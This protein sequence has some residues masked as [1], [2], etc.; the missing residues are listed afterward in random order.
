MVQP[1]ISRSFPPLTLIRLC[2]TLLT[3]VPA[4]LLG[5]QETPTLPQAA[6]GVLDLREYDFREGPQKEGLPLSGEWIIFDDTLNPKDTEIPRCVTVPGQWHPEKRYGAATYRITLLMPRDYP[7]LGLSLPNITNAY[8]LSLNGRPLAEGG[9]PGLSRPEERGYWKPRLLPL[10][11]GESKITLTLAFSNWEDIKGGLKRAPRLSPFPQAARSRNRRA[12]MDMFLFGAF[13][14]MGC[15][16]FFIYY[17]RKKDRSTLY[18]GLILVALSLRIIFTGNHTILL[19]FPGLPWFLVYKTSYLTLS[20]PIIFFGLFIDSL[21][22]GCSPRWFTFGIVATF[23]LYALITL[24]FPLR[25]TSSVLVFFQVMA[26]LGCLG[27]IGVLTYAL[28]RRKPGALLFFT[29]FLFLFTALA[30]DILALQ[31]TFGNLQLIPFGILLFVLFQSL[32]IS[33][34]FAYALRTSHRLHDHLTKINR[35]MQR[36]VPREFLSFL[37]RK[38]IQ[39]VEFGD[40][41]SREM[42]IM[43]VKIHQFSGATHTLSSDQRF[44]LLN[45]FLGTMGPLIRRQG[46]FIDKYLQDGFM[47]LFPEEPQKAVTAALDMREVILQF[48]EEQGTAF[49]LGIGIHAGSLMLGTIGENLRM[50][51]TVISDAVNL[52]SRLTDISEKHETD[53]VVS[54]S[55]VTAEPHEELFHFRYLGEE[56]LKGKAKRVAVYTLTM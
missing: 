29:G 48:N 15:Y 31:G 34:Q 6:R 54:H 23:S 42:T 30:H 17:F 52:A 45:R 35:S 32:V 5:A 9:T 4:S 1:R 7:L 10:P 21:F 19:A 26:L 20:V 11:R 55:C 56:T 14:I 38:S 12:L 53:I 2:I 47:A 33:R 18:F 22:P 41:T 50:D 39:D 24:I 44:T 28:L 27:I 13:F 37:H 46:G 8:R 25:V 3:L 36:F 16:H 43:F 51:S 49:T 40:H